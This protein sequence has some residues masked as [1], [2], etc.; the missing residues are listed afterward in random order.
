[1]YY[2]IILVS[3][4]TIHIVQPLGPRI[5]MYNN[6]TICILGPRVVLGYMYYT[7]CILGPRVVLYYVYYMY[8]TICILGPRVVL[9]VLYVL[10]YMYSRAQGCTI[11][12]ICIILYVF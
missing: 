6:Y 1:M 9:C 3:P 5:H 7:I 2:S 11:C 4:H 12:T 8:Y 10:Y